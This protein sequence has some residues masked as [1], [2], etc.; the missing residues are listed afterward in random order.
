MNSCCLVNT[1][2]IKR[3]RKPRSPNSSA[4]K[5][6]MPNNGKEGVCHTPLQQLLSVGA[7]GIRPLLLTLFTAAAVQAADVPDPL[8][9][10]QAVNYAE[11]NPRSQL[12]PDIA[13]RHPAPQPLYLDCHNLAYNSNTGRQSARPLAAQP[14]CATGKTTPR[15]YGAVFRCGISRFERGA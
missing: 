1:S 14:D 10:D 13:L 6:A 9:L 11:G 15:Y 5:V 12:A 8:S 3:M 4:N 2:S 7:Y